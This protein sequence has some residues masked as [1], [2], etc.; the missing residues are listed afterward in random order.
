MDPNIDR[1]RT[2][3]KRNMNIKRGSFIDQPID[4]NKKRDGMMNMSFINMFL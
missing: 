4:K 2:R 1:R 3:N